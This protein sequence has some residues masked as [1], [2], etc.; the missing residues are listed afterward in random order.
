LIKDHKHQFKFFIPILLRVDKKDLCGKKP[1]LFSNNKKKT[2][3]K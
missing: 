3:K 1:W 2:A